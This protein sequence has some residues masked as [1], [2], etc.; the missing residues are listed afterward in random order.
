MLFANILNVVDEKRR[1]TYIVFLRKLAFLWNKFHS[2]MQSH[3]PEVSVGRHILEGLY[4]K[5]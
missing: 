5:E 1:L 4:G 3:C 2:A